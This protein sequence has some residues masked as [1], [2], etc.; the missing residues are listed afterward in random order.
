MN[1]KKR[2]FSLLSIALSLA[3]FFLFALSPAS[4]AA[5]EAESPSAPDDNIIPV[6]TV[7]EFLSA[8][9]PDRTLLLAAGTYDLSS[10]SGYG[11]DSGSL[12]WDWEEV[13]DGFALR[14]HD[15]Y[16]LVMISDTAEAVD[17]GKSVISTQPRYAD[18]LHFYSCDNVHIAALTVGHT[19]EPGYCAGNVLSFDDCI[20]CG[21]DG[22]RLYGCGVI[23]VNATDCR[24]LAV[25]DT[26]IY[27]CSWSAVT[28]NRCLGVDLAD[29]EVYNC[30]LRPY[31]GTVGALFDFLSCEDVAI[32]RTAIH[33]NDCETLLG[34]AYSRGVSFVSNLLDH[35]NVFSSVFHL[36]QYPVTVAGCSF[37]GSE[38]M[39]DSLWYGDSDLRAVD[40]EGNSLDTNALRLMRYD[41]D[42]DAAAAAY[43]PGLREP[44]DLAPGESI[45]V[46]TVDEF[47][48]A[49][50]PDRTILLDGELFDLSTAS[51]Y[52]SL[53]A[54][55]YY[56][57]DDYDGP[58]L[59]INQVQNL[60]IRALGPNP[61]ATTIAA[62]PRYADVL[63]FQ[64]CENIELTGLTLGHTKEPG[65][66]SGGVLFLEGCRNITVDSCRLYGCGTLGVQASDCHSM[67]FLNTEIYDCSWGGVD[68]WCCD[69]L[70]FQN[71]VIHDVPSPALR[72]LDCADVSWNDSAISAL[73]A[74][75]DPAPD[76][77][78]VLL[79]YMGDPGYYEPDLTE[80]DENGSAFSPSLTE[81]AAQAAAEG[82]LALWR[83]MGILNNDVRFEGNPDEIVELEERVGDEYWYNRLFPKSYD[84][85]W[86]LDSTTGDSRKF[87]C[88]IQIDAAT[89]K[90]ISACINARADADDEPLPGRDIEVEL[91]N[92]PGHPEMG[93][94]TYILHFYSNF[95]DIFPADMTIDRFCRLLA[96]YWG[97]DGYTIAETYDDLYELHFGPQSGETLLKDLNAEM[98][99]NYYLTV[100]FD[101]DQPGAPMYI[102]LIQFPGYVSL[103]V[104][105][106]H[107]VG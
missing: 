95:D 16:N 49:V 10:A 67:R 90:I 97:F 1:F 40:Q 78:L 101:G 64:A 52:G 87:G 77:S 94:E 19:Q 50:G 13:Y 84:V 104:G 88:N 36:Q 51:D 63:T 80:G 43:F 37:S 82:Q 107:A 98:P 32:R 3:V 73:S 45:T 76:G 9:G 8:I 27:E 29:C 60:S 24:N 11:G 15:T 70:D 75:Y 100:L 22:C 71:C 7:D 35:N 61:A 59:V 23:G 25:R 58:G 47:L 42:V 103:M 105:T 55:Y 46:S 53:G 12:Y 83:D 69:G 62:I 93:T 81:A 26:A 2:S 4:H 18:V 34:S 91:F 5:A 56:W 6:S 96:T 106:G 68:F 66:C 99:E 14:I 33:D 41:S 57:S 85:R 89:G 79:R 38:W 48:A 28:L 65:V 102:Q 21:I 39:P 54:R 20:D 30:G 17:A 31:L 44:V 74:S 72:F 92:V 86:F